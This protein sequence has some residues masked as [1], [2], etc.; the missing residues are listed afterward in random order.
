MMYNCAMESS[1]RN[2]IL[3]VCGLLLVTTTISAQQ[4][5]SGSEGKRPHR[6]GSMASPVVLRESKLTVAR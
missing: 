6:A 5:A 4:P 2:A 3:G 1:M